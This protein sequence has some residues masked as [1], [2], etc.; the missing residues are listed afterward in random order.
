MT[1]TYAKNSPDFTMDPAAT[2]VWPGEYLKYSYLLGKK[3]LR[4]WFLFNNFILSS[5][6]V[7]KT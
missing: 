1:W 5:Y 6:V 3:L 2:D 4:T 7:V